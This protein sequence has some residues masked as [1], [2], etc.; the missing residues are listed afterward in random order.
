MAHD[1]IEFVV[2]KLRAGGYDPRETSPNQWKARCPGHKGT[3]QNLSV[4]RADDG[5]LL[6]HCHHVDQNGGSCTWYDILKG[7]DVTTGELYGMTG[8]RQEQRRQLFRARRSAPAAGTAVAGGG[9]KSRYAYPTDQALLERMAAKLGPVA[10]QWSYTDLAGTE[11]FRI[12]RLQTAAGKTFRPIH[13]TAEGWHVGDPPGLRPLYGL[14]A[15]AGATQ[16]FITEGEKAAEAVRRLPGLVATTSAHGAKSPA[17]TDWSPLAG[18]EVVILPDNDTAGAGYATLVV[19]RLARLTPPPLVRMVPLEMI[20]QTDAPIEAGY[21]VADWLETG[22]PREWTPAESSQELVRAAQSAV[23]QAFQPDSPPQCSQEPVRAAASAVRQAF[24]P[25][26]PPQCSQ[27][28]VRAAASASRYV[29][30]SSLTAH[31]SAARSLVRAA[32]SAVRQAFQPDSPPQCS[33]ELVRAAAS[34]VRQAFQPDSPP[35]CSHEP[36]RAAAS[37]VR[38]AFQ[39]DSPP[40]CSQRAGPRRRVRGTS[41]FP[42]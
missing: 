36:V 23:R 27:E 12:V 39:P 31:R 15:L 7:L 40:Q 16:V 38:Q 37:A 11:V 19:E 34:A 5:R 2:S 32:G 42:A 21:D 29:R 17:W 30:L 4:K 33:Q 9:D 26:S 18:K 8:D 25:D 35:Q 13:R 20:W 24:Q 10:G 3:S 28:P 41:G 22:V 6:L 1:P 14:P